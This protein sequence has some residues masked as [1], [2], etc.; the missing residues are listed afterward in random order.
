MGVLQMYEIHYKSYRIGRKFYRIQNK[1]I[2]KTKH[3]PIRLEILQIN[4]KKMGIINSIKYENFSIE[5]V[6]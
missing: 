5:K 6:F 1:F 4:L 2:L 3:S